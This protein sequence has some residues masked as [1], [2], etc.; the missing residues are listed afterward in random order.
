MSV[1]RRGGVELAFKQVLGDTERVL[2]AWVRR[3]GR[4]GG[5]EGGRGECEEEGWGRACLGAGL[6]G[7]G[8][9]YSAPGLGG[10]GGRE[11]GREGGVS[12]RKRGE[13][14]LALEQVLG[15]TPPF[16][17]FLRLWEW[18]NRRGPGESASHSVLIV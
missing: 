18:Y 9:Q 3:K 6:G 13:I 17:L 8:K 12:V 14:E 7:Y 11:G 1:R 5:R 16:D 10:E 15:D 2:G 4:E